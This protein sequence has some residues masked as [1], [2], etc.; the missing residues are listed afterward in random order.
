MCYKNLQA[1]DARAYAP[2]L[3]TTC[4][5][6]VTHMRTHLRHHLHA[7]HVTK[8]ARVRRTCVAFCYRWVGL[9]RIEY[10]VY[11]N[12]CPNWF[13][14]IR[15]E[16]LLRIHSDEFSSVF[17]QTRFKTFF[18]LTRIGSDIDIEMI[19][20]SSDFGSE[21]IPI[22]NFRQD[23]IHPKPIRTIPNHFD[24]CILANAN[25]YR[26]KVSCDLNKLIY[27]FKYIP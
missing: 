26:C 25:A 9:I 10:S 16:N 24:I 12:P 14:L 23:R 19:R 2:Y 18:G 4:G 1:C 17:Q 3:R 15:I 20:N 5:T 27:F 21:W 13:W 22:R 6:P 11:I 8:P 7:W